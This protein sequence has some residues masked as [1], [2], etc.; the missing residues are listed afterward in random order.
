MP[1]VFD[2][3]PPK[4]NAGA[5]ME[6]VKETAVHA[7]AATLL[8][9]SKPLVPVDTGQMRDSGHVVEEAPG[10]AAVV[11]TRTPDEGGDFN[12][13]ALQHEDMTLNHPNGGQAKYLEDPMNADGP[14]VLA[15]MFEVL[16]T[17]L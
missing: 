10:V 6:A 11:Y 7:G 2:Y 3:T 1:I 4:V 17:A 9:A 8:Q 14:A 12:V 16:R 5:A 15:A 13:A